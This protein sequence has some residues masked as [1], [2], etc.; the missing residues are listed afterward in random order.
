MPPCFAGGRATA[1]SAAVLVLLAAAG[2]AL[3]VSLDNL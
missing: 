1:V 2:V 3:A